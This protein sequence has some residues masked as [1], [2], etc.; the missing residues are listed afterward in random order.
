MSTID[1]DIIVSAA[2]AGEQPQVE[3][4]ATNPLWQELPAVRAGRVITLPGEIY[5]GG[6]YVAAH[7]L[8]ERLAQ[9]L[10]R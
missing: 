8:L 7:L 9:E 3:E 5:N 6:T 1:G 10:G 4:L 2:Y